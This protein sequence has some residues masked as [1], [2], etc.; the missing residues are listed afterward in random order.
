MAQIRWKSNVMPFGAILRGVAL[1][2]AALLAPCGVSLASNSTDKLQENNGNQIID[3]LKSV[4]LPD[5]GVTALKQSERLR[6]EPLAS[7]YMSRTE[8]ERLG[9]EGMKGISDVVP[10]FYIPDYGSRITSSIYVRGI[11]ARM[12]Q[13]SVGLNIDNVPFLNKD[14]YDFDI[15][16]IASIEMLRGPQSTLYGRNTMG[17]VINISTLSPMRFQGWRVRMEYGFQKKGRLSVGWYH[18]FRENFASSV[19]LDF[20]SSDGYFKNG[21]NGKKIDWEEM[22][23][24][25]WKTQWN[26]SRELSMQNT[27]SSSWLEQG[28]YPYRN[29]S[30]DIIAYNDTCFY[31][32]FLLNDGLTIKLRKDSFT[33]TSMTSVQ[34]IDDNMTLDQDFLPLDYFTLTQKKRETSFTEDLMLRGSKSDYSWLA[35]FFGFYKNLTM[36]AP[37][38]FKQDGIDNLIISHR[39]STNPE[40]PVGWDEPSFVLNSD[41]SMPT[42]GAALYHESNLCLG[43]WKFTAGIRVDF[44]RSSLRYHSLCN[45]SYTVYHRTMENAGDGGYDIFRNV[46][47]DIDDIGRLHRQYLNWTPKL[48]ALYSLGD[49]SEAGNIYLNIAKG[50]KSGGFNTQMFSDVLQQ[51]LM[52]VMGIGSQY[53]VNSITGYRPEYSWNFETGS[54]LNL[55]Q[56]RLEVDLSLFYIDCRDQQLTMFPPGMTTGRIMTNAG[57]TR[58][59][60]GEVTIAW[61]PVESVGLNMS[62]GYTN[63]KFVQYMDGKTD[64]KGKYLPYVPS[65]TLFIQALWSVPTGND[66]IKLDLDLNCRG[67][68]RIY[69]N[70]ANSCRQNFYLLPGASATLSSGDVSFQLWCRNFTSTRYDTFYFLSMGNEFLQR[71]KPFQAGLSV[72]L[73]FGKKQ[74][75]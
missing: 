71:G 46:A 14:A 48:S 44:E 43:R 74:R 39:N 45:T 54:H 12:D 22:A 31:K 63:A 17:G 49:G 38:T 30:S 26:P 11:G 42:I 69:W 10:N 5:L 57:K 13:P 73:I 32:R 34:Y 8:L 51:R 7:T 37:V 20:H 2:A 53:D 1:L 36:S 70:E 27:L 35:G 52:G 58:S 33:L 23:G 9:V 3:T 59:F 19:V 75:L 67:T 6:E 60:G 25:R 18:K 41:F 16:D 4:R 65:N 56:N 40:Y 24:L 50:Y 61:R 68:G 21:F 64:Y 72:R 47:I 15:A 62:Y 28:G 29:A 66:K 55:L